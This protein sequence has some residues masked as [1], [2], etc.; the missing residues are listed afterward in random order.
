VR[1][2][3]RRFS[4]CDAGAGLME[5]GLLIGLLALGLTGVLHLYRGAVGDVTNRTAV[6]IQEQS[7]RGYGHQSA[8][9]G[10]GSSGGGGPASPEPPEP[11]PDSVS[12]GG[13]PPCPVSG[14]TTCGLA[15]RAT[16]R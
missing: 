3:I 12:A 6:T 2:L 1:Q 15:G 14:S 11:P 5:Y 8:V 7:A 9:G 13:E 10:G 16:A 4:S